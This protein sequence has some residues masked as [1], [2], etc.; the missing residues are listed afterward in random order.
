MKHKLIILIPLFLFLAFSFK[1]F[2][3]THTSNPVDIVIGKPPTSSPGTGGSGPSSI[4]ASSCPI[5]GGRVT[6]GSKNVP[7][8]GCGHCSVGYENYPCNYHS[9]QF[10][11]DISAPA[12]APIYM[13]LVDGKKIRWTFSHQTVHSDGITAIQ[14]YGGIDDDTQE[15][16]WIQFHHA[17]PGSGGGT[18]FSGD[19]GAN[20]CQTGCKTGSGPHVHVEFAKIDSSGNK[21]WQEAPNY[22]CR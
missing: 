16:Y 11:I 4:N 8:S 14:Y 9:L 12:L 20:I 2:S 15:Q 6:C 3:Q 5:P 18:I 1:A 10:A 17:Q 7:V 21:I 19:R 13:P 22:F